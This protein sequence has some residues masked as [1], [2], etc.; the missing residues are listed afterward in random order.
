MESVTNRKEVFLLIK[1]DMELMNDLLC[2]AR[3]FVYLYNSCSSSKEV[4]VSASLFTD[5]ASK[6]F[7]RNIALD[8]IEFISMLVLELFPYLLS[9]SFSDDNLNEIIIPR[10]GWICEGE[11]VKILEEIERH[12]RPGS[13]FYNAMNDFFEQE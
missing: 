4:I 12:F 7:G 1:K 8:K 6:V 9:V 11:K 10:G 5:G 2:A 13:E 3:F